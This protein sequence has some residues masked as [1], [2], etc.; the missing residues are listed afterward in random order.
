[1][2]R[3]GMF[4]FTLYAL[5][6]SAVAMLMFCFVG[7]PMPS[8]GAADVSDF[9]RVSPFSAKSLW[10][11]RQARA[12]IETYQVDADAKPVSEEQLVQG[13]IKGMVESWKDP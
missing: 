1:M 3:K 11:V 7:S 2:S 8:A 12:I 9:E 13:A 4:R 5:G 10:L 6:I